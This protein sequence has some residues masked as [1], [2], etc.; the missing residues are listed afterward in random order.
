L[1]KDAGANG[2]IGFCPELTCAA[3]GVGYGEAESGGGGKSATACRFYRYLI[4]ARLFG[5]GNPYY[6][7]GKVGRKYPSEIGVGVRNKSCSIGGVMVLAPETS[8]VGL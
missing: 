7:C 5:I 4:N 2:E 1:W 3:S 8:V 6:A